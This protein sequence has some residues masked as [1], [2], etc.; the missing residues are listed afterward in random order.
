LAAAGI[1]VVSDEEARAGAA[2]IRVP[3][4]LQSR[5]GS[6]WQS[7]ARGAASV[8]TDYLN[9]EIVLLGRRRGIPTPANSLLQNMMAELARTGATEVPCRETLEARLSG[10]RVPKTHHVPSLFS[11]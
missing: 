6:T 3:P 5:G 1:D 4:A 8:E 9:G 7:L 11:S 2:L 10:G